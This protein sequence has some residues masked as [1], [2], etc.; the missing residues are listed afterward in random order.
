MCLCVNE[1]GGILRGVH[2]EREEDGKVVRHEVCE[3][4]TEK[5]PQSGE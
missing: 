1:Q 2:G 4:E 5:R 3:E